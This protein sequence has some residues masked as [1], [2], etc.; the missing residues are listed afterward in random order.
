MQN[1]GMHPFEQ[2][3]AKLMSKFDADPGPFRPLHYTCYID[4]PVI[5]NGR[6]VGQ[7]NT[8]QQPFLFL[9]LSH[10]IIG[11]TADPEW[12]GLYQDGQYL[13]EY[14]DEMSNYQ[15]VATPADVLCGN[16]QSGF[17]SWLPMPLGLAGSR[18][19]TFTVENNYTR[20]LTPVSTTFRVAITMHGL[21]DWG[22]L[23]PKSM[24]R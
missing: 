4:V 3:G 24:Q 18:T 13:I 19:F 21:A 1:Q 10:Q 15:N 16:V 6:G 22:S 14:R 5:A 20:I 11:N 23:L 8:N 7:I 17:I 9:R 12:S 2:D